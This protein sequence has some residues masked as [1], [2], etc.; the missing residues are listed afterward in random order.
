MILP[1]YLRCALEIGLFGSK[2][3]VLA[4]QIDFVLPGFFHFGLA[5]LGH[6]QFS[7]IVATLQAPSRASQ[8]SLIFIVR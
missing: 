7:L 3:L 8:A 2:R 6:R 4:F 5:L 1:R